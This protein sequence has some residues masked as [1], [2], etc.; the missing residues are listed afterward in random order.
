MFAT[1]LRRWRLS[2]P[3]ALVGMVSIL[4][5]ALAL[6][7]ASAHADRP[8]TFSGD[9]SAILGAINNQLVQ[10][11]VFDACNTGSIS[12]H[13]NSAVTVVAAG[14]IK[15]TVD[16]SLG[17]GALE[18]DKVVFGN[19]CVAHVTS[20]RTGDGTGKVT[21]TSTFFGTKCGTFCIEV[22]DFENPGATTAI[23]SVFGATQDVSSTSTAF[24]NIEGHAHAAVVSDVTDP[25]AQYATVGL[26][27]IL[28]IPNQPIVGLPDG[29]SGLLN[30]QIVSASGSHASA[31]GNAVHIVGPG[32]N[33]EL[34]HS[35]ANITCPK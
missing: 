7:P 1:L 2:V 6:T 27:D 14:P 8:L 26:H 24:C 5:G 23:W 35:H 11:A 15:I 31:T 28:G 22:F 4:V 19:S 25:T 30:E 18:V 3:L 10:S 9:A 21:A 16:L 32:V 33:V 17:F 20:H 13:G 29:F 34:G 12:K